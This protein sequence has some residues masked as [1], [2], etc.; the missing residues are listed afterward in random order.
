MPT[1]SYQSN[2]AWGAV[3][4]SVEV[5]PKPWKTYDREI[6]PRIHCKKAQHTK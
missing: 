3:C 4:V 5:W 1:M 2:K 6:G